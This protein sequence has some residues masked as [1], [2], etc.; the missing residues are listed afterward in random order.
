[1][2]I[3]WSPDKSIWAPVSPFKHQRVFLSPWAYIS[4]CTSFLRVDNPR[5]ISWYE[6]LYRCVAPFMMTH[7]KITVLP[8]HTNDYLNTCTS[9][10]HIFIFKVPTITMFLARVLFPEFSIPKILPKYFLGEFLTFNPC[11][12]AVSISFLLCSSFPELYFL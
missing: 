9:T 2:W 5:R 12:H 10:F 1:M 4:I 3:L 6:I 8:S 11:L 7:R